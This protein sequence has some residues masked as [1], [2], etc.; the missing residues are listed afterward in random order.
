MKPRGVAIGELSTSKKGDGWTAKLTMEV[1][2]HKWP[3]KDIVFLAV[4]KAVW[5]IAVSP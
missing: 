5:K 4:G 3:E 2:V 1:K